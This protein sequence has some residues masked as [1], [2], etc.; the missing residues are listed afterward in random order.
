MKIVKIVDN[1]RPPQIILPVSGIC[2]YKMSRIDSDEIVNLSI[3]LYL[4]L[5]AVG[6]LIFYCRPLF[7][8]LGLGSVK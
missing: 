5:S 1:A 2:G 7:L 4:A 8:P 3:Y 6:K